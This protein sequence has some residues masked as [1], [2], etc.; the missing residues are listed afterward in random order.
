MKIAL[1]VAVSDDNV[2]GVKNALPWHMP[3]DLKFFKR[4]TIGKPVLMGR[5]T[6][7]SIRKPLPGRL[8][9]VLSGSPDFPVPAGVELFNDFQEAIGRLEA[10]GTDEGFVIG[11]RRLFELCTNIVDRMYITRVHGTFPQGDVF[12]P[13]IDHTQWRLTWEEARLKDERHAYDYTFQIFERTEL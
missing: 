8:N 7:E 10:E 3:E 9:I 2:I 13:T 5:K 12:F 11:G 1:I 4:H 6:F